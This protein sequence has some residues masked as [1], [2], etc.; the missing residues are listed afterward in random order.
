MVSAHFRRF[1]SPVQLLKVI[2]NV[3]TPFV[4]STTD[5]VPVSAKSKPS[6]VPAPAAET[7]RFESV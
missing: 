7:F 6:I 4:Q 5:S 3:I 1:L 2:G